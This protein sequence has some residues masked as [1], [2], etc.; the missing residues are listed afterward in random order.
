MQ[1]LNESG[2]LSRN[3]P[4]WLVMLPSEV[5]CAMTDALTTGSPVSLS[6]RIPA[7][8]EYAGRGGRSTVSS[9]LF[10]SAARVINIWLPNTFNSRFRLP[11]IL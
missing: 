7:M 3:S 2:R 10:L 5:P 4:F 11:V 1:R 6:N 9:I 8:V